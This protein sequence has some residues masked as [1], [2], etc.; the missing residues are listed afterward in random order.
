MHDQRRLP[1]SGTALVN[2]VGELVRLAATALARIRTAVIFSRFKTGV[3]MDRTWARG[4][5]GVRRSGAYEMP[6]LTPPV[7]AGQRPDRILERYRDGLVR[8]RH[9]GRMS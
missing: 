1:C 9:Y 6:R 7:P 4:P 3:E 2:L 8:M 5:V